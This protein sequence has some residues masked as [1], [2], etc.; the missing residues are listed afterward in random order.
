MVTGTAASPVLTSL[1]S[2]TWG[3]SVTSRTLSVN[4][5]M[6]AFAV[7]RQGASSWSRLEN[8]RII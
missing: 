6:Q 3:G 1:G 4:Q 7:H 8:I 2:V 5:T